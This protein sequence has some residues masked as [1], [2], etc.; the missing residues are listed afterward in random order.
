MPTKSAISFELVYIPIRPHT[1]VA[2]EGF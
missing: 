1:A 2:D